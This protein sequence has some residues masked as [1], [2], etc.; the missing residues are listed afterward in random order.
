MT[1][2]ID[3][4]KQL[5]KNIVDVTRNAGVGHIPSSFSSLEILYVL[6][7]KIVNISLD[8]ATDKIRDRVIISKEHCYAA[9]ICL[10]AMM[11]LIPKEYLDTYIKDDG[12][13]AHDLY[14][15]VGDKKIAALDVSTG[16]LGHGLGVGIGLAY[17][18][19]SN[20]Y[21]IVGDGE[22]QEGSCWEAILFIGQNQIKNL[23]V[24]VDCNQMQIDDFTKNIID[25]S[26]DIGKKFSAFNFDVIECDGHN[27]Q[28]LEKAFKA[29]CDKPK[30]VV[31]HTI[32]GKE[33]QFAC[34]NG[35]SN[36]LFHAAPVKD[37]DYERLLKEIDK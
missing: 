31:A 34:K 27:M 26:S 33:F 10:F 23:T 18:N 8:N 12:K 22:L 35:L 7:N 29:K 13:L 32:K 6:Y 20:V 17:G 30:C 36:W 21:V 5:K 16:S 4:I 2:E 9:R 1:T 11:G 37:E 15:L 19:D 14:G 28:E 25:T 24:V 3:E